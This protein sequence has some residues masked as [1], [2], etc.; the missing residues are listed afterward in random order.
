MMIFQDIPLLL[1]TKSNFAR[2][3]ISVSRVNVNVDE[4]RGVIESARGRV[5]TAL[6]PSP[7]AVVGD[8][9]SGVDNVVSETSMY[10]EI[11]QPLL[12][13]I[14][15]FTALVDTFSEVRIT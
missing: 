4:M 13:K 12:S 2:I 14:E 9:A 10:I 11:W 5:E 15:T 7:L 8:I 6:S 1:N 3:D